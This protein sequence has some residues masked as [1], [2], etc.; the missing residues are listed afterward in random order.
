MKLL[1]IRHAIAEEREDF[2]RTGKD[3]RLRPLTDEGRKKM[4]QAARGLRKIAPGHRPAGDQPAD[5]RRPDRR[6]RRFRLR[7]PEGGRDRR[8]LPRGHPRRLPPLAAQAEGGLHRRRGARAEHQPAPLLAAD[9]HASAGSSPSA[10]GAPACS[11]SPTRSAPAPPPW[12]GRSPRASSGTSRTERRL[13]LR[14]RTPLPPP[15]GRSPPARP[16]LPRPGRRG[17][18]APGGR[19]RRRGA[20]RL[21]RRPAPAAQLPQGLR[22]PARGSIPKKLA[23][24]LQRLAGSTGPGRDTEVQIEW[25]RGRVPHLSAQH[26]A[27]LAWL[28]ARLA[29]AQARRLRA[30]MEDEVADEFDKLE[31]DL[32]AR[33][34]VYRAEIHLDA[35]TDRP[36]L[37]AATAEHPAR[38]GGGSRG[39]PGEDRG[40]RRRAG[41]PRGADPRQAGAL[42]ARAAGGRD[43]RRRPGRQT[44]QG[45]PGAPRRPPRR[46]R[47]GS[48]ARRAPSRPPPPNGRGSSSSCRSPSSRRRPPPRRAP[49]RPRARPD[50]ARP[51]EP[52]PPRPPLR[53]AEADVAGRQGGDFLR[54][55]EGLGEEMVAGRL[56]KGRKGLQGHQGQR[57]IRSLPL[58]LPSLQSFTSFVVFSTPRPASARRRSPAPPRW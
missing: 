34:S 16:L 28:L 30:S 22:R 50:R 54:E 17:P 9:R 53:G 14:L 18:A 51:P 48:R 37:A 5:P 1:L 43:P 46:P 52:R 6:H 19:R 26:R 11:T 24:R 55:V 35:R 44:L 38:P 49:A 8:A 29:R 40:R 47:P 39:A 23:R 10:R 57:T 56:K 3:D 15:R 33:L 2:A 20:P 27:G 31:K 21:P 7:R 25:L 41:S 12:S 13:R 4:K 45:P 42:P 32:R 58:P 36:T